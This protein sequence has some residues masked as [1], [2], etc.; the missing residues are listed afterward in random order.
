MSKA[1]GY[2]GIHWTT[3]AAHR[4]AL[5]DRHR[6]RQDYRCF[7]CREPFSAERPATL[8]HIQPRSKGGMDT[9]MN[10]CV[11]CAPCNAERG[12]RNHGAFLRYKEATLAKLDDQQ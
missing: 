12:N 6:V 9:E 5:R 2:R 8:E 3:A 4:A 7:Y 10:T 11:S 1:K